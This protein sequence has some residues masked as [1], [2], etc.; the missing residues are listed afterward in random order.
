MK[1]KDIV[2]LP[3][4]KLKFIHTNDITIDDIRA[5]FF[6]K[7]SYEK[8]SY[9]GSIPYRMDRLVDN[10]KKSFNDNLSAEQ[11]VAIIVKYMDSKISKW[12]P[13]WFLRF[14]HLFGNDNSVFKVRNRRLHNLHYKLTKGYMI[15]DWKT[16]WTS[17]DLRIHVNG[18]HELNW[19]VD[20]ISTYFYR[21]GRKLELIE[22]IKKHDP[23]LGEVIN[24]WSIEMLNEKLNTLEDNN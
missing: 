1:F 13:R 16:K 5:V 11:A 22:Q 12:C 21:K 20:A 10:Q 19:L 24:G 3:G 4:R 14:L 15:C 23:K 8:Y 2:I 7:T 17:Y 9:L 18:D 6:P